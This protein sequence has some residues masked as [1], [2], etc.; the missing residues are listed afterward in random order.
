MSEAPFR[1]LTIPPG[2]A[3]GITVDG[4]RTT[5]YSD[6]TVL[7]ALLSDTGSQLDFFCAIG[8]CQ[9]C[10]VRINGREDIA[11]LAFPAEGDR[12]ETPALW[13]GGRPG[14]GNDQSPNS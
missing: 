10:M 12:I 7:A 4:R 14:T 11:C 8:Q 6:R 13:H 2:R 9:R 5:A 3:V 1:R